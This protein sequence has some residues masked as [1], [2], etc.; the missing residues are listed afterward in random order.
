MQSRSVEG[1]AARAAPVPVS[2]SLLPP[3][4]EPIHHEVLTAT[5]ETRSAQTLRAAGL[6]EKGR[7]RSRNE[8][9]FGIDAEL[10]LLA[11]ADGLGGHNAGD[12]AARMAVD[13]V[14]AW[15]TRAAAADHDW[16]FG[17]DGAFSEAA[18][19]LRTAVHIANGAIFDLARG[20]HECAGMST[21]VAVALVR[22]GR[23]S[24][25]H[26]G[27]SR[28]YLLEGRRLRQL[29]ADDTW[30]ASMEREPGFDLSRYRHHPVCHALTNAV[31]SARRTEVHLFEQ[32]LA[33]GEL[34]L[35][36]TDGVHGA[37][38]EADIESLLLAA[39]QP[40]AAAAR[41]VTAALARGS[42]DNCTAVVAAL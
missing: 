29:T 42:R 39:G 24:V 14:M 4:I 36:T 23:L 18:N 32:S 27:D 8:D 11:V 3:P 33:G 10:G 15:L 2:S 20:T 28:V 19:L 40:R 6:T 22:A 9:C 5:G 13:K 30:V 31:G 37:L 25:A 17:Y 7:F 1:E 35:L 26:V 41:L 34:I 12:V 21:T 16:A 38:P